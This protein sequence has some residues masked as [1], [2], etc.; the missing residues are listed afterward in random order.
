MSQKNGEEG[1]RWS[2]KTK[3]MHNRLF[4]FFFNTIKFFIII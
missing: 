2:E 4:N 1:G 3:A